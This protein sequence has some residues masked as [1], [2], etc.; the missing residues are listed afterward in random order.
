MSNTINDFLATALEKKTSI[1]CP[2]CG[3]PFGIGAQGTFEYML[4]ERARGHFNDKIQELRRFLEEIEQFLER[5]NYSYDVKNASRSPY[6][7]EE[8]EHLDSLI[9]SQ[10]GDTETIISLEIDGRYK[11]NIGEIEAEK[12]LKRLDINDLSKHYGLFELLKDGDS[13]KISQA[14]NEILLPGTSPSKMGLLMNLIFEQDDILSIRKKLGLSNDSD[15][16]NKKEDGKISDYRAQLDQILKEICPFI[17]EYFDQL[18]SKFGLNHSEQID[19]AKLTLFILL[20]HKSDK[21]SNSEGNGNF[22]GEK[23]QKGKAY[24]LPERTMISVDLLCQLVNHRMVLSESGLD[25][26]DEFLSELLSPIQKSE[27]DSDFSGEN[28]KWFQKISHVVHFTCANRPGS[29]KAPCGWYPKKDKTHS[30]VLLGSP[31]T[32]KTSLLINGVSAMYNCISN[33]GY[34]AN[35]EGM[36]ARKELGKI[37]KKAIEGEIPRPNERGARDRIELTIEKIKQPGERTHY[38]FIDVAG[39][40]VSS[41]TTQESTETASRDL[42]L[43]LR[44]A[45]IILYLFDF[46]TE[47][48]IGSLLR[49]DDSDNTWARVIV[50][51][52][53]TSAPRNVKTTT[54]QFNLLTQTIDN[55][56][57][58]KEG[59]SK[60]LQSKFICVIPKADLFASDGEDL[61]NYQPSKKQEEYERHFLNPFYR[62]L[63]SRKL[64]VNNPFSKSKEKKLENMH[65]LGGIGIQESPLELCREI[66]NQAKGCLSNIGNIFVEDSQRENLDALSGKVKAGLIDFLECRFSPENTYFLPVSAL[67]GNFIKEEQG[68]KGNDK[69]GVSNR[70]NQK[71][72]EF[73]FLLPILLKLEDKKGTDNIN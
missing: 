2:A 13:D 72:S 9:D 39:E 21:L 58:E 66:S 71:L 70:R 69:K 4:T 14:V 26:G 47:V 65:S 10:F 53:A 30:V 54:D 44:N 55:L 34:I 38:I 12:L 37:N 48:S 29:G 15:R 33:L 67:G 22:L 62:Y 11:G 24:L 36:L 16:K 57:K 60:L 63:H 41:I 61:F 28:V 7:R 27:S 8:K 43:I 5:R 40:D 32:G 6:E 20:V 52:E 18:H 50:E 51:H 23:M 56:A 35:P 19:R 31:G 46:T 59:L 49:S 68:K 17:L 25:L 3:A 1:V 42:A 73:V 45:E 64:I